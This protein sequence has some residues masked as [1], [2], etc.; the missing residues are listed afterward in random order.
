MKARLIIF[1]VTVVLLLCL[2]FLYRQRRR[3][4][5]EAYVRRGDASARLAERV[6]AMPTPAMTNLPRLAGAPV[7]AAAPAAAA[8]G[9]LLEEEVLAPLRRGFTPPRF[10]TDP[11]V[12]RERQTLLSNRRF[13]SAEWRHVPDKASGR[14]SPTVR[15]TTPFIVQFNVPV[16]AAARQTLTG[17]G[18]TV[19]GF[20]PNNS[21]LTELTPAALK[22]LE[23]EPTVHAAEEYLP[24]DKI[25]PFLAYLAAAQPPGTRARVMIQTFAPEATAPVADA[26][27]AAGGAVEKTSAAKDRG[28]VRAVLPLAAVKSLAALGELAIKRSH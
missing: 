7:T 19:R 11:A 14:Q 1:G 9:T 23:E 2:A 28:L 26:V 10:T 27:K 8:A 22:A 25:Q 24:S 18:A 13:E 15:G 17:L 5:P 3:A 6:A 12:P 4:R 16:S 20:F 21:I